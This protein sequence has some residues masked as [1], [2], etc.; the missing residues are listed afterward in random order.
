MSGEEESGC[1]GIGD[2]GE[3][4][5]ASPGEV[6]PPK[7]VERGGN[8][9]G[10]HPNGSKG[11]GKALLVSPTE[12][13]ANC[14]VELKAGDG[15]GAGRVKVGEWH[16]PPE[17]VRAIQTLTGLTPQVFFDKLGD[18]F[19]RILVKA[20]VRLEKAI[21]AGEGDVK[22][23]S[24]LVGIMT[25]KLAA[26]RGG[27][28]PSVTNQIININGMSAADARKFLRGD[29]PA[30]GGGGVVVVEAEAKEIFST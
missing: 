17:H 25:D 26:L 11:N 14:V 15:G 3:A 20:S 24:I 12:A 22:T 19:E 7:Q 10:G 23:L 5:Y 18:G 6:R 13:V 27:A 16:V 30:P 1:G 2:G 9:G 21:D 8:R 29:G 4:V 28:R